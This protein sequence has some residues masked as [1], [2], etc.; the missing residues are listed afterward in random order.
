MYTETSSSEQ[1]CHFTNQGAGQLGDFLNAPPF[2]SGGNADT[3]AQVSIANITGEK[4]PSQ[5]PP[6]NAS[7]SVVT[8]PLTK[9]CIYI[10]CHTSYYATTR[11]RIIVIGAGV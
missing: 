3:I 5:D 2:E 7:Y 4:V 6:G 1:V 8:T 9:P 11:V 10:D